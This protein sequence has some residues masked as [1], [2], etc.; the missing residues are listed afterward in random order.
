ML[1]YSCSRQ[2][3]YPIS[4]G[5]QHRI[6]E[7]R[8]FAYDQPFVV[9]AL[10][11]QQ[12]PKNWRLGA[13]VR[14]SAGNPYTPVVNRIYNLNERSFQPVYGPRDSGRIAPFFAVDVR[15]DRKYVFRTW[16]FTA[17]LDIQNVTYAKNVEL[18]SWSYDYSKE[19]P[20]EGQPPFP[21]FGFRGEW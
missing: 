19:E 9:N 2:S 10:I 1:G 18:M 11:S 8:L 17:Y 14:Y 15:I 12:L 3:L 7:L 13:R 20:I 6:G 5:R 4:C 16:S 21:A